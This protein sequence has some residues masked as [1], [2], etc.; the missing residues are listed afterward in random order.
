MK[1][2]VKDITLSLSIKDINIFN[3]MSFDIKK[4]H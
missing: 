2:I 1:A 3:S 4:T